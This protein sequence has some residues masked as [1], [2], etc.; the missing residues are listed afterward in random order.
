MKIIRLKNFGIAVTAGI[1]G[2]VVGVS[3]AAPLIPFDNGN[4]ADA[5]D[6]NTNFTELETRINTISLTPG[7]AGPQGLAGADG[8]TGLQGP[9][10]PIGP[11]GPSGADGATGAAGSQ[12]PAGADGATGPAGPQGL[13]GSDGATG[14]TGPQ[15]PAGADGI[16]VPVGQS[17]PGAEA[18]V[19]FDSSG[20][21][22]CAMSAAVSVPLLIHDADSSVVGRV[23]LFD[24]TTWHVVNQQSFIMRMASDAIYSETLRFTGINCTG[25]AYIESAGG[26][27]SIVAKQGYV[28]TAHLTGTVYYLAQ[29]SPITNG[30]TYQSELSYTSVCTNNSG[31]FDGY[32]AYV[33]VP[34]ITGVPDTGYGPFSLQ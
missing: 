34:G 25:T 24:M 6:V 18:V 19:G 23:L 33:N 15:G 9:A 1:L 27:Y 12:G 29:N 32:Q 30:I 5:N 7:P 22:I 16:S 31:S 4:V 13:A 26:Y 28:F 10:G 11:Q 17:C 8:A 21:I 3:Q 14:A 20:D 2:L